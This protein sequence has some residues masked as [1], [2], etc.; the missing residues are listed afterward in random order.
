MEVL[1]RWNDLGA[2]INFGITCGSASETGKCALT[3]TPCYVMTLIRGLASQV[4]E[5][6]QPPTFVELFF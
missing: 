4:I 2:Q 6:R 5:A 3:D 1:Y